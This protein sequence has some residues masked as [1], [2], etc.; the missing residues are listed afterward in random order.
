M[1]REIADAL[2]RKRGTWNYHFISS[3][4][5][6]TCITTYFKYCGSRKVI[7]RNND[8]LG[9]R[10]TSSKTFY[11]SSTS[12]VV[13]FFFVDL[14]VLK[15]GDIIFSDEIPQCFPLETT[16][17]NSTSLKSHVLRFFS[18]PNC[19]TAGGAN[20]FRALAQKS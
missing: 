3:F 18:R 19:L 7:Y 17:Q 12:Q 1:E 2:K 20:F 13:T 11:H 5:P 15:L 10:K 8:F 4:F 14:P 6:R 9:F 16:I